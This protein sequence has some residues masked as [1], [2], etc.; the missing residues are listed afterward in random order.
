[1]GVGFFI[2]STAKMKLTGASQREIQ[3]HVAPFILQFPGP[4]FLKL[5]EAQISF[6]YPPPE[7]EG[8]IVIICN[9]GKTNRRP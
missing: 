3:G 1:M 4:F 7:P 9:T 8:S 6:H 5:S 2:E